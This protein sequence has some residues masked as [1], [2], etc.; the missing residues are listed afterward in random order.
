MT[1]LEASLDHL[2]LVD[3]LD[4]AGANDI[5][6]PRR[7]AVLDQHQ[8]ALRVRVLHD[9]VLGPLELAVG[10]HVDGVPGQLGEAHPASLV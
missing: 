1:K 3:E 8:L 7:R 5:E 6:V 4:R 10:K 2:G 9:G